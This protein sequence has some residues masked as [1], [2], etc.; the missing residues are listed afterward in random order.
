MLKRQSHLR[1]KP[2]TT[3]DKMAKKKQNEQIKPVI[4]AAYTLIAADLS[5][6]RPGFCKLSLAK[7]QE[8][9]KIQSIE[10]FSVDNK[11]KTKPRGQLLKEISDAFKHMISDVSGDVFFVREKSV[12]NCVGQIARSG[13]AART[14]ISEV[15][16]IMDLA[17]WEKGEYDWYEI[18]PVT[19]KKLITG[20]GKAEKQKVA[21]C[22]A[23]Y[24]T[25]LT[26]KNDDE[27]DAAAVAAAWLIQN[28]QIKQI[29]Q[30]DAPNERAEESDCSSS[31]GSITECSACAA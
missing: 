16:G 18:Y 23:Q 9:V 24:F 15:V 12:N 14:G 21:D 10:L 5:L 7:E 27:S 1:K 22:V 29:I 17:A 28:D 25:N 3:G 31:R 19:I 2:H 30:E 6:K 4:P 8:E 13:T 11:T 26:F 20:N